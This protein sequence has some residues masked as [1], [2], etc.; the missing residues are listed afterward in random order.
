MHDAMRHDVDTRQIV[1][2]QKRAQ[3][4]FRRADLRFE[5]LGCYGARF[6]TVGVKGRQA[7]RR[8]AG[9]DGENRGLRHDARAGGELKAVLSRPL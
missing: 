8:T 3:Q 1:R 2:V 7:H 5:A 6:V 9:V 4:R